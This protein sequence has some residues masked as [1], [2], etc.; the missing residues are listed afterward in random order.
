MEYSYVHCPVLLLAFQL[1]E[2]RNTGRT[3]RLLLAIDLLAVIGTKTDGLL[4]L[5]ER[6][7]VKRWA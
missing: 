2:S 3:D 4:G 6:W 7:A 1:T 5:A